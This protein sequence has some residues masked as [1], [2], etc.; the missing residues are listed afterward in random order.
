[1]LFRSDPFNDAQV[2]EYVKKWF[3]CDL[4]LT[5]T[6]R[7]EKA[8]SFIRESHSVPD[9]RTNPLMLA[10]MCNIYR[11]ENYIPRNRPDVYEKCAVMLF[12]KWDKSRGIQVPLP[13]EAHVRPAMMH[14][15]HWVFSQEALL[16]G[17]TETALIDKCTEYLCPRRYEDVEEAR[18]A[19]TEFIEFCRG[20]AWVFTDTGTTRT[21]E[22]LYQ[23]THRT[24]LE[25]FTAAH[26]VRTHATPQELG[27]IL[28]PRICAREW[29]VVAQLS[30]QLQNKHIEGAGD[31]LLRSTLALGA[32][33]S[34]SA[35][36][37]SLLSFACR[38][39]EF[40]VPSPSVTRELVRAAFDHLITTLAERPPASVSGRRLDFD[41][42]DELLVEM[43]GPLL[44]CAEEN[45]QP[46]SREVQEQLQQSL[47][48]KQMIRAAISAQAAMN[49]SQFLFRPQLR[50]HHEFDA[51]LH[52]YW[53]DIGNGAFKSNE[54]T[55]R[56]IC[57]GDQIGRASCRE[58]V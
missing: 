35:Q 26:L 6:Q 54:E 44:S 56:R 49:L 17:V 21:G 46:V 4:E 55:S 19:A 37:T 42:R 32:T 5:E 30:F 20:R 7:T 23:F 33:V 51:R 14:L 36:R 47:S 22:R 27:E 45:R 43:I 50:A 34:N 31:A 25:Y 58:T 41:Q 9:L 52:E 53:T 10:L 57:M 1:M 16:G 3:A 39:L 11:G 13:F 8:A 15:A 48:S 18:R 2:D 28:F 12:E 24:F 40:L 29:D 38:T